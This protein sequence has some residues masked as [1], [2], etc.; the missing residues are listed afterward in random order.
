MADSNTSKIIDTA[1]VKDCAN[2]IDTLNNQLRQYL[3]NFETAM[4]STTGYV[5]ES[6]T[7]LMNEFDALKP[8]FETHFNIIKARADY[9]KVQVA[10]RHETVVAA[11]KQTVSGLKQRR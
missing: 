6:A 4:N 8:K 9:L 2:T 10:E 11:Q 7:E 5:S 3:T 1:K